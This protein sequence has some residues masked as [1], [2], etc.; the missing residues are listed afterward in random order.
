MARGKMRISAVRR[1]LGLAAML[2]VASCGAH[3]V[4]PGTKWVDTAPKAI[5]MVEVETGVTLEV[6]DWGGTGRPVVLLA[7]LGN[8]A[9]VFDSF[10]PRLVAKYHVYGITRRGYGASSVPAAGYGADRLGD[11]VVAVLDAMKLQRP[12]LMGHSIAGEELSS[13]GT[14]HAARVAGL[15]YLDAVYPYSYKGPDAGVLKAGID[16]LGERVMQFA[17]VPPT[18]ADIANFPAL[19]A[20]SLLGRGVL[21]PE[22]DLRETF[23]QD[24]R[25]RI[26]QPRVPN[27]VPQA[28]LSGEQAYGTLQ[29]PALAIC[30]IP[31]RYGRNFGKGDPAGAAIFTKDEERLLTEQA[32]AFQKGNPTARVVRLPHANHYVFLSNPE[33]VVRE[34]DAFVSKLQ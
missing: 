27:A 31:H 24:G 17:F 15:V 18:E 22:A 3:G 28:I 2:A 30:G 20:W 1:G 21:L 33:D 32:D 25:G 16:G 14:R 13:I 26:T 23:V 11:D 9:H 7:G 8:T 10:A 4:A 34:T 29:A 5:R 12:V 19:Q 6:L